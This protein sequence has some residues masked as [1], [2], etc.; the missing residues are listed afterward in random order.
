MAVTITPAKVANELSALEV[1]PNTSNALDPPGYRNSIDTIW[2]AASAWVVALAPKAPDAIHNMGALQIASYIMEI[3]R[4]VRALTIGSM[5]ESY[6]KTHSAGLR[7]QLD[8]LSVDQERGAVKWL[9]SFLTRKR[10]T[11]ASYAGVESQ[12]ANALLAV[13][14][15]E[16]DILD[17]TGAAA[18]AAMYSDA[19]AT[20]DVDASPN[21]SVA[22]TPSTL[23]R[24]ATQII[25]RGESIEMLDIGPRGLR[26]LP[27]A[28]C[29]V[30]GQS[31]DPETWTY[32]ATLEWPSA[33]MVKT[34]SADTISH[35]K[36]SVDPQYPWRGVGP[37]ERART[38][39]TLASRVEKAL[40]EEA[41]GPRGSIISVPINP[42]ADGL[43]P[44]EHAAAAVAAMKG[45]LKFLQTTTGA[46]GAE[47]RGAVDLTLPISCPGASERILQRPCANCAARSKPASM[48]REGYRTPSS[49]RRATA[50]RDAKRIGRSSFTP[51]NPLGGPSRTNSG[52][53]SKPT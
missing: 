9:P 38:T 14:R 20:A 43:D 51:S 29:E 49:A 10:E 17:G 50:R 11:R 32:R 19:F 46:Y 8:A 25:L 48:R 16:G 42:D 12:V 3:D 4:P 41:S 37:L 53:S 26:F 21:A 5:S 24:M 52:A 22:L 35:V 40:G 44:L 33:S 15:G 1:D 23:S 7:R 45:G 13:A 27:V 2:P 36:W 18:A 31:P 39:S 34:A 6:D 30:T 28:S 47:S